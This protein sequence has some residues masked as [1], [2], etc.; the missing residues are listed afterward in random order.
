MTRGV[1]LA[2]LAFACGA[3]L[4]AWRLEH[5]RAACWRELAETGA[6]PEGECR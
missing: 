3:L 5:D 1:L 6:A 4:V 2:M